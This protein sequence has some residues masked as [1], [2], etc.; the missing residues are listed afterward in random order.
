MIISKILRSIKGELLL[1][2]QAIKYKGSLKRKLKFLQFEH[3]VQKR[4]VISF[5]VDRVADYKLKITLISR[6]PPRNR[7]NGPIVMD[8]RPIKWLHGME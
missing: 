7:R 5:R 2:K 1:I 3:Y 4:G 8:S 6:E